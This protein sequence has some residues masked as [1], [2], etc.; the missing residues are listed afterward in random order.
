MTETYKIFNGMFA[1]IRKNLFTLRKKT[2][3]L[4]NWVIHWLKVTSNKAPFFRANFHNK[5]KVATFLDDFK[6]KIKNWELY[7]DIIRLRQNVQEDSVFMKYNAIYLLN[8]F[9]CLPGI[10]HFF[11]CNLYKKFTN[12]WNK[13]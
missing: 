7:K 4:K 2:H 12:Y 11:V 6:L 9:A 5:Y 10:M 1:T 13:N 3:R 8:S